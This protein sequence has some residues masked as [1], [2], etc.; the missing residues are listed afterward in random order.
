LFFFC[1]TE[2]N[3]LYDVIKPNVVYFNSLT[4]RYDIC[5]ISICSMANCSSSICSIFHMRYTSFA[6]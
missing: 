2:N 1:K 3:L 6:L 4:R 5:S